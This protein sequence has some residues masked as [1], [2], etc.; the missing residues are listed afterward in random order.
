L[1]QW[2]TIHRKVGAG[3][4]PYV[5]FKDA[6]CPQRNPAARLT[7]S[8]LEPEVHFAWMRILQKPAVIGPLF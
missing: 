6:Q 2:L 1:N 8:L 3:S 7:I 5:P 4:A